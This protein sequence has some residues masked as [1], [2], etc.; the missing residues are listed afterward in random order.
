V[1]ELEGI[2]NTRVFLPRTNNWVQ[3]DSMNHGRWYP[4][5][6]TLGKG[7]VFVAS[8]VTKLIKPVYPTHPQD[9][10]TNVKQ[11]ETY[12]PRT[13]KWTDNGSAADRSLP[14]FPRLHLLPNG[15][16]YYDAAGQAFNPAGQA[17]DEAL[18][19]VAAVYDPGSKS[20]RD[21]GVPALGSPYGGFR[22]STFSAALALRP[23]ANKMYSQ[24]SYLT[25]GGVLGPTPGS[26]VSVADS[27]IDTVTIDGSGTES[28]S[29]V[30]TGPLGRGRWY[31]T[32]VPL[33][34]GTVY[35]INGADVDEVVA[36]GY[37]SPIT[38][39]ELF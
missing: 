25:A 14:L 18:W 5:L 9:S 3:A 1:I 12:D 33:P 35:T 8:G 17:Y 6:V 22:G 34:D 27:R 2:R 11:T 32:A 7:Q 36:P 23:S 21:L 37:E 19:N 24:A 38:T 30:S 31:S 26:F 20:W 10:G 13:D 29:T 28:S 15:H 39:A 16:V 4:A